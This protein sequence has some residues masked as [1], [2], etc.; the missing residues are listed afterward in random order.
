M[1]Y[2]FALFLIAI[3]AILRFAVSASTSGFNINTAGTIL[4]I[5]GIVGLILS[6]LWSTVYAGRRRM[7]D[8]RPVV[9]ERRERY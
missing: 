8:E 7:V 2:G 1:T 9:Y 4:M 5:V 3:G 6:F